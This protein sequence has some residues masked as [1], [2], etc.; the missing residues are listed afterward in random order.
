MGLWTLGDFRDGALARPLSR[1]LR[2][3]EVW[4]D[5][6]RIRFSP[7]KCT[8]VCFRG[9]N[10]HIDREFPARLN[11]EQLP[12]ARTIRYLGVWFDENLSWSVHVMGAVNRAKARLCLLQR[13]VRREWGLR[14]ELFLRLTRGAVL[15][16]LFFGAPVWSSI[17]RYSSRL[18][19]IDRVLALAC[20]MAFGLERNTSTEASLILG[21]IMPARQQI[22]QRLTHY[23]MRKKMHQLIDDQSALALHRSYVSP[24]ELGRAFFQRQVRGKTTTATVPR[25]PALLRRAIHKALISEWRSRWTVSETGGQLR[26]VLGFIAEGWMPTDVD[27][28]IRADITLVA[29]FLTGHFHLDDWSPPWDLDLHT[30]CPLCGEDFSRSHLVWYCQ[31]LDPVREEILGSIGERKSGDLCWLVQTQS[32]RLGRFL[33]SAAALIS[34]D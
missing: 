34:G 15:P 20:R 23:M 16:A 22:M 21:G 4:A 31:T 24:G 6:W 18:A 5:R 9:K 26:D 10:V 25:R 1:G 12:H 7:A 17:L 28:A 30:E 11:G 2:T 8:C 27:V 29:R 13:T 14:P 19:D 33:R 32:A 3:V